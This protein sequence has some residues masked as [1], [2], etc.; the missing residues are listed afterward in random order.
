MKKIYTTLHRLMLISLYTYLSACSTPSQFISEETRKTGYFSNDSVLLNASSP[1]LALQSGVLLTDNDDAFD[2]K[3]ALINDALDTIDLAYYIFAD[4]YTS[5]T[6]SMALIDAAKRGVNV[7][8]LLDYHSNYKNLDL[9]SMLEASA[10]SASGSIEVRFYNRPTENQIKDS[11]YVTMGCGETDLEFSGCSATKLEAINKEIANA[12]LQGNLNNL[13]KSGSGLFLSGLYAKNPSLMVTAIKEGY[14][15][16]IGALAAPA[17]SDSEQLESLKKLGKL[18]YQAKYGAG[19][20]RVLGKLK[21]QLAFVLYG[22]QITPIYDIFSSLL[23][24]DQA[25]R[26]DEVLTEWRY[27]SD[28]LHHKLLL[29]DSHKVQLG[30]RNV[31]DSYHM[32]LNSMAAK[33]IF[34]DTDVVLQL[35]ENQNNGLT[36]T[37]EKLWGFRDMVATIAD[38]QQHAPNDV[39]ISMNYASERCDAN[40]QEGEGKAKYEQ[41]LENAM[42]TLSK[43]PLSDRVEDWLKHTQEHANEYNKNYKPKDVSARSQQFSIDDS[44][45]VY[46]IE[47]LPFN[48]ATPESSLARSF[49]ALNQREG[50]SGKHI[51]ATWLAALNNVCQQAT[52]EG[53]SSAQ[54]KEI[55]LHNA[56]L[57]LPSNILEQLAKMTDGRIPCGNVDIVIVTNSIKTTDLNIVNILSRHSMK[58]FFD[59]FKNNR[60]PSNGANIKYYEYVADSS[61]ANLSLHTKVEVFGDDLFVG[62]ANADVRSYMMDS[63][64]GL[65]IR[66]APNLVKNYV[67]WVKN[68]IDTGRVISVDQYFMSTSRDKI[69]KEDLVTIDAILAKYSAERWLKEGDISGLKLHLIDLLGQAYNL[70]ATIVSDTSDSSQAQAQFNSLFKTI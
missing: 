64:N 60:H 70:S 14:Q 35:D 37:F 57:F 43:I 23:P 19:I 32:N 39:L 25:N 44:A 2:S 29:V 62:S 30:G 42:Q 48:I 36:M 17:G 46:Y 3:L 40:R 47:N 49:G 59:H 58:A 31:E 12:A 53:K 69:L 24:V 41:C 22:E 16:N 52:T 34:M 26:S 61:G 1:A 56:Y 51:H 38:I 15:I 8:M 18:Y 65:F 10:L 5:S 63:N 9:F 20:D 67:S 21:L 11:I 4:D 28:F 55:I 33:Y 50:D 27:F 13:N 66:N 68:L 54:P 7:R 6:L 45:D